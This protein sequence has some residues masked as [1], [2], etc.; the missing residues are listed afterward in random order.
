[1]RDIIGRSTR[2][3]R[4]DRRDL[5]AKL[6]RTSGRSIRTSTTSFAS[7]MR[8]SNITLNQ[9]AV[10]EG[11]AVHRRLLHHGVCDRVSRLVQSVDGP[12]HRPIQRAAGVGS[13]PHESARHRRGASF[14]HCLS[15]G[16]GRFGRL[17]HRG[18][19]RPVQPA[20]PGGRSE[21]FRKG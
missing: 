11:A 20:A 6:E 5:L 17:G 7:T 8:P 12:G 16:P 9:V 4:S 19:A 14:I 21:P 18:P 15:A 2:H 10:S 1:M 3:S 13:L